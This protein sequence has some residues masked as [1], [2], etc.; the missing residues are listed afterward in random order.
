MFISSSVPCVC[1]SIYKP[2]PQAPW[3]KVMQNFKHLHS[4][5]KMA[6]LCQYKELMVETCCKNESVNIPV[7]LKWS[8]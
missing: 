1:L 6:L 8:T 3:T 4:S 7:A 5:I 2:I